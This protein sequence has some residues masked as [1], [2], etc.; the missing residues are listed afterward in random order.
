MANWYYVFMSKAEKIEEFQNILAQDSSDTNARRKL[1]ILLLDSGYAD[2]ALMHL[3]YLKK[4]LPDDSGIFYNIGI[5]CEKLKKYPEAKEAYETAIELTPEEL[6]AAYNLGLVLTELKDYD[7]AIECFNKVLSKDKKDSNSYFNL[8]ICYLKKGDRVNALMNF[9]STI[10]L[11]D[12][13]IYAHFYI[14]NIYKDLGETE[15]AF[16]EFNKVLELSPDYSWAYYNLA[17]IFWESGQAQEAVNCLEKTLELNPKD[18]DAYI[19]YAKILSA[20]EQYENAE[21][22]ILEAIQ[23]CG[24]NGNLFYI[25]A[26]IQKHLQNRDE[27]LKY[28]NLALENSGTLNTDIKF[29]NREIQT[30]G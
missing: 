26:Q 7:Y 11:N 14:G 15:T 19:T 24:N 25:M 5:A 16:T 20:H 23:N 27:S 30:L 6:D 22:K 12:E 21:A 2:E 10:E 13:D 8:G 9:Q 18:V 29:V 4:A 17:V 1:A 3:L 28:F